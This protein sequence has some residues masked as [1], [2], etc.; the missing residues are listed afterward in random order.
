MLQ[1]RQKKDGTYIYLFSGNGDLEYSLENEAS[2]LF[3]INPRIKG[4]SDLTRCMQG[5]YACLAGS[6]LCSKGI[7]VSDHTPKYQAGDYG[8]QGTSRLSQSIRHRTA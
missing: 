5:H 6:M 4:P 7:R 8:V 1:V 2:G 3:G